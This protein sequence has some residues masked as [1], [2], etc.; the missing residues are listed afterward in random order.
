MLTSL[1]KKSNS[2]ISNYPYF[3]DLLKNHLVATISIRYENINGM[4][5]KYLPVSDGLR[6]S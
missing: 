1:I 4:S 3:N 6:Y 2:D 5:R